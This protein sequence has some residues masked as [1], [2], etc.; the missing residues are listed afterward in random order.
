M[1]KSTADL[2]TILRNVTGR[3]D[4]SDPLFTDPIMIQYLNDFIQLESTQDIR[5][6][7]NRTWYEF[8]I[9]KNTVNP[10][11]IDLQTIVMINGNVGASTLEP[12]AYVEGFDL[13]WFQDPAE[14]Y[15]RWPEINH[16]IPHYHT[17]QRPLAVLWYNNELTFPGHFDTFSELDTRTFLVKIAAYQVEV[18]LTPNGFIDQD[19]LYRYICYGAALDI[20]SD[21]GETDKYRD[22]MPAYM[23][24][25]S[26]VYA[27]TSAQYQNQRPSPE[28]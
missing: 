5:I 24:Y 15:R 27:R 6:F 22:I 20:F 17:H 16:Q 11:P 26:L 3:V 25:R 10:I 4:S 14:F 21:Y 1:A 7:K 23:R 9:D 13:W 8:T 28:F 2:V 18:Q 19:Y 12:P